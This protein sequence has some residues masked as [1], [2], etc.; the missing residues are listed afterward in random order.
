MFRRSVVGPPIGAFKSR[1]NAESQEMKATDFFV[2]EAGAISLFLDVDGTLL[3]LAPTPDSVAVPRSLVD[4]LGHAAQRLEGALALV[5]GR[6]I[7]QLDL[8]FSPLRLPASG[9]HGAEIRYSPREPTQSLI[10]D[11]LPA[12]AWTEFQQLLDAFPGSLTENKGASFAAHYNLAG[13][14]EGQLFLALQ[15]FREKFPQ[16]DLE[17]ASGRKVFELKLRGFDKGAA[18]RQ[19]MQR[20]PFAGRRPVFIADD[21]IDR[22]GFETVLALGGAAFSVGV[23]MP[24]LSGSFAR[25]AA[26]RQWLARV[27]A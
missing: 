10:E 24:G 20:A 4:E 11:R 9:V 26:V 7:E 15:R 17:L 22:P 27:V 12:T 23:E 25:P 16:L 5:S 21:K 13:P 18:I 14:V 2:P 6:P 1:L 3:D 8:L 19:F